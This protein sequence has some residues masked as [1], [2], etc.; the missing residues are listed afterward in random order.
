MAEKKLTGVPDNVKS[1]I[2]QNIKTMAR[3]GATGGITIGKSRYFL[4]N[5]EVWVE[6]KE[7]PGPSGPG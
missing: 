3:F 5:D 4:K 6:E 7:S 1:M 2:L